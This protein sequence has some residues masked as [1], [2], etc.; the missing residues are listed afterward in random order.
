MFFFY[1]F[2]C[3]FF[4]ALISARSVVRRMFG[5]PREKEWKRVMLWCARHCVEAFRFWSW[6]DFVWGPFWHGFDATKKVND[7]MYLDLSAHNIVYYC[8]MNWAE[9]KNGAAKK[10]QWNWFSPRIASILCTNIFFVLWS[11]LSSC[12]VLLSIFELE[13]MKEAGAVASKSC[14]TSER[15]FFI[16]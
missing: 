12:C 1:S 10:K 3:F 5:S 15:P 16:S 8:R 7:I 4:H 9:R 6:S 14:T 11:S 13:R 2:F